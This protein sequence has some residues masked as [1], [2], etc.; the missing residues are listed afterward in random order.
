LRII[1]LLILLSSIAVNGLAESYHGNGKPT[2]GIEPDLS[3]GCKS[4]NRD[5]PSMFRL[6]TS[7][8][9]F[10][11]LVARVRRCDPTTS[12]VTFANSAF[13]GRAGK[14][15]PNEEFVCLNETE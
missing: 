13:S 4:K 5:A 7:L 3:A 8:F 10:S 11:K 2:V 12:T 14:Y 1:S 9:G 15:L 6:S